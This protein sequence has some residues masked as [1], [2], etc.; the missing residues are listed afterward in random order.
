MVYS[1]PMLYNDFFAAVRELS[2]SF[3]QGDGNEKTTKNFS[4]SA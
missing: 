4:L 2:V 3:N 1:N